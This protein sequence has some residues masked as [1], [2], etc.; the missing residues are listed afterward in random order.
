EQ[1]GATARRDPWWLGPLLTFL[2]LLAFL[3]YANLVVFFVPGYF[4]IRRD[5]P[6]SFPTGRDNAFFKADNPTVAPY[7]APFSSP[8][9]YD[10][11][12]HHAW[13]HAAR[14]STWPD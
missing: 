14:P 11:H 6:G 2:G 1:V 10:E 5:R 4:E 9:I 3:I 13:I 7:L 8:L 12:S